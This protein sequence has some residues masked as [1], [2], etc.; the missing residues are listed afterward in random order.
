MHTGHKQN[1]IHQK[2]LVVSYK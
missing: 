2:W 1:N